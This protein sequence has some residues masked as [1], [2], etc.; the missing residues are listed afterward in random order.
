MVEILD[1]QDEI[2]SLG[3]TPIN[4][5]DPPPPQQAL[6]KEPEKNNIDSNKRTQMDSTPLADIMGPPQDQQPMMMQAPSMMAGQV[7]LP[8][9]T[10][11]QQQQLKSKNMFNLSDEQMD[12]LIAAFVAVLVFSGPMQEK[13]AGVVPNFLMEGGERSMSGTVAAGILVAFLFFFGRRFVAKK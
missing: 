13:L 3:A 8:T 10:A 5:P 2:G 9:A 1:L 6:Q 4:I 11:Q 7:Q 12:A